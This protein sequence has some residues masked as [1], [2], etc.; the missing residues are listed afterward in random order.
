[1]NNLKSVLPK[2]I[3]E[4][5]SQYFFNLSSKEI[6]SLFDATEKENL[7]ELEM[8]EFQLF[9]TFFNNKIDNIKNVGFDFPLHFPNIGKRN[10]AIVA[11]DP[12]RNN[13]NKIN[14]GKVSMGSVFSLHN[15]FNRKTETNDYWNFINPLTQSF[16]IYLTD[17]YKIYF[18][19]NGQNTEK[20]NSRK[21]FKEIS[22][23]TN[24]N[25]NY[26]LHILR[27]ELD[28]FFNSFQNEE[29][30]IITLGK[31]SA[32]AIAKIYKL[33]RQEDDIFI[34][35]ENIKFIFIPHISRTVTQNIK[36]VSRLYEAIGELKNARGSDGNEFKVVGSEIRKLQ[37]E[38]FL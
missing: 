3:T 2:G 8:S 26:H 22:I 17:L 30:L 20:K 33:N 15:P 24:P 31:E 6:S 12:K 14:K 1:M 5:L 4:I 27:K 7:P 38:M 16:N 18:E 29:N 25:E 37:L 9:E 35:Q 23:G 13:K 34:V 28:Y 36:T 21:G 19:E 11:L 10:L 32:N